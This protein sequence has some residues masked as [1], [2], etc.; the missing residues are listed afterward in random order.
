MVHGTIETVTSLGRLPLLLN[1]A[2]D[3]HAFVDAGRLFMRGEDPG[4][5]RA[6]PG[7]GLSF[8]AI[9]VDLSVAAAYGSGARFYLDLEAT[10]R[11]GR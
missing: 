3:G 11:P 2:V 6:A 7:V 4:T 9:G 8:S 1:W 10:P 5:W